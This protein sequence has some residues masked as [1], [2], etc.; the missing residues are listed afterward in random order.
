MI[1]TTTTAVWDG[2]WIGG[3]I[4]T[5][6]NDPDE[7]RER[8]PFSIEY[9]PKEKRFVVTSWFYNSSWFFKTKRSAMRFCKREVDKINGIRKKK[10]P[11]SNAKYKEMLEKQDDEYLERLGCE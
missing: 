7:W 8:S 11:I 3:Q 4:I 5:M 2:G 9:D 6:R 10:K 1:T